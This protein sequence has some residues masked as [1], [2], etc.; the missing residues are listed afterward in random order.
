MVLIK[1]HNPIFKTQN[2]SDR[3]LKTALCIPTLNA[4]RSARSLLN[5]IEQQSLKL[6]SFIIIDSSSTDNT[7]KIFKDAGARVYTIPRLSFDHGATRQMGVE[8]LSDVDVIIFMTQDAILASPDSF[9]RLVKYFDD[10]V[11]GAVCGRQL[12]SPNARPIAIHAR[13]FNYPKYST[14]KTYDDISKIGIK[15][16]FLSNSFAAYRCIALAAVGGFPFATIFGEDT[17][18]AAKML[19]NGW[20]VAYCST[21]TV[22]HSHNL[23]Y[24]EEFRRYFDI[25]VFHSREKWFIDSLGK[26]ESE[27]KKFVLSELKYLFQKAPWLIPSAILRTAIKLMGYRFGRLEARIPTQIKKILSMNKKY[28]EKG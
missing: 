13:N 2:N 22:Y 10:E 5:S 1:N 8:L 6:T 24:I 26:A 27:G 12:P 17:F 21:A 23:N 19:L 25:G 18:V 3:N 14:I 4:E 28:W 16:A 20:K 15:A 9:H 7:E 11:V